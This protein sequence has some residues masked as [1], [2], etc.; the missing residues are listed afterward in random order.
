MFR[1]LIGA[2]VLSVLVACATEVHTSS[3]DGGE[4]CA[5]GA[6]CASTGGNP[7]GKDAGSDALSTAVPASAPSALPYA[8]GG[9]RLEALHHVVEGAARFRGLHDKQLDL[10]C[11]F[12]ADGSGDGFRCVPESVHEIIYLDASCS[13]PALEIRGGSPLWQPGA[14]LSAPTTGHQSRC[15]GELPVPRASYRIGEVFFKGG[16]ESI[17]KPRPGIYAKNGARCDATRQQDGYGLS[18]IHRLLPVD[19]ALLVA[20]RASTLDVGG[21]LSVRRVVAD[22][23]TEVTLSVL[24]PDAVPC[25][26]VRGG[27]CV[28]EPLAIGSG[29]WF[30]DGQCQQAALFGPAQDVCGRSPLG[31]RIEADVAH[32]FELVAMS[33]AFGRIAGSPDCTM[34]VGVPDVFGAGREVSDRYPAARELQTGTAA[35][36][37]RRFAAPQAASSTSFIALDPGGDFL[38]AQSHPCQVEPAA[39]GSL[40]C[41][42][43]RSHVKE[44]E[45]FRDAK[46]SERLWL[47]EQPDVDVSE[48]RLVQRRADYTG[49]IE[50]LFSLA[51]H[52]APVYQVDQTRCVG[53]DAPATTVLA[54][55]QEL[56]LATLVRVESVAL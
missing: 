38:D 30:L 54:R 45:Y 26:L 4:S 33:T 18:P 11:E 40:R 15:L 22:D 2:S 21:G 36:H 44:A 43:V 23:G 27:R 49:T 20:G 8:V 19:S 5:L 1:E 37:L 56:P 24:G 39:D 41:L 35:L 29:G 55:D 14:W 12:V 32:V 51:P 50:A 10:A 53:A 47:A 31:V 46:C 52:S 34:F 17:G 42:P 9:Q 7:G 25:T 13:E 48:L 6:G 3:A 16:V 28:P